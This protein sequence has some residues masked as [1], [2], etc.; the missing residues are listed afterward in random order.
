MLALSLVV[1]VA[2]ADPYSLQDLQALEKQQDWRELLGHV[3]DIAPTK[4][5][6]EW[7]RLVVKAAIG[8]LAAMQTRGEAFE[9]ALY[10][11]A[12]LADVPLLKTQRAF[13]D[14]R[15][16]AGLA[17]YDKC[18]GT[19]YGGND[20]ADRLLVFV[21][22][23]EK[24]AALAFDAAKIVRRHVTPS[25]SVPFFAL[26]LERSTDKAWTEKACGDR[27]LHEAVAAA[28]YEPPTYDR[29]KAA[30]SIARGKCAAALDPVLVD[31][32]AEGSSYAAQNGCPI[33]VE[34]KKL[35]PFQQAYCKDQVAK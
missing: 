31:A 26:A 1:L 7:Q 9:A 33:L 4:R 11:D 19:G 5:D 21:K 6:A 10:A 24:N 35:T 27:V 20:C 3:K 12:L 15:A 29:A 8:E 32:L 25:S 18:F 34:R 16:K 23:D 14:E 2:A 17:G 13:L 28:L 22:L 30:A